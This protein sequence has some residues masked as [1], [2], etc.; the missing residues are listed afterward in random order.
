MSKINHA[1]H[2][3]HQ[4]DR[5]AS[6]DQWMNQMHPLVKLWLTLAYVLTVV[7]FPKYDV[8]GL[9]A[10]AVYIVISFSIAE[11]SL[12]TCVWRLRI[13]LPLVCLIGIANPFF[14]RIPIQM[15]LI[16]INTGVLSMMTLMMKGIFAVLASYLLIATTTIEKI[17][18]ALRLMHIPSIFVTQILLTYRY[19]TL[20]LGEVNRITQAYALRAPKQKGIHFKA[21]GSLTGQLL[22]RSIDRANDVYEGMTLR[23]YKGEFSHIAQTASYR[24]SDVAYLL[25]WLLLFILMRNVPVIVLLGNWVGGLWV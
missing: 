11:L 4:I 12:R 2:E 7:S 18:Y 13:V 9:L 20:L 1:I 16:T 15:G 19:I 21:W 23:G 8:L 14:D 5:I 22:L 17:C 6:K 25:V 3:I 10:M 24:A